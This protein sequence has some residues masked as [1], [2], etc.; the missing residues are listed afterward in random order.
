M[1]ISHLHFVRRWWLTL[2]LAGAVAG[3]SGF[4]IADRLPPT[5]QAEA[6]VL[7]GPVSADR[8]VLEASSRLVRTFAELASSPPV[9]ETALRNIGSKLTPADIT[10][11]V[12]VRADGETR[13]LAIQVRASS[14]QEA[15]DL[16]N[17]I[18]A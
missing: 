16:A 9:Q 7:V 14:A 2:L 15:A 5:Y 6:K 10:G 3:L 8:D 11:D 1:R 4:L 12:Q 18:A 17:A 13:I